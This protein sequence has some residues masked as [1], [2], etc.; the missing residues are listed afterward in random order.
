M[1]ILKFAQIINKLKRIKR[2]GWVKWK[3]PSPESVADHYFQVIVLTLFLAK[4]VEVNTEKALKMAILHDLGES[5]V[6]D[7]ITVG[8]FKNSELAD[9]ANKE[10]VGL[11]KVLKL[12][13][14]LEFLKLFKEFEENKTPEAQFVNQVDKLEMLLQAAEYENEYQINLNNFFETSAH[15]ITIPYLKKILTAIEKSRFLKK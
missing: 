10:R 2:S 6:G 4:K 5:V 7:L 13:D 11:I 9:K 8:Q 14:R 1:D 15:K 12:A 3:V